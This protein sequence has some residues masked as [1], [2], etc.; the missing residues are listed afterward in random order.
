[1]LAAIYCLNDC[2][3]RGQRGFIGEAPC[4]TA[5]IP[6]PQAANQ[7]RVRYPEELGASA[8]RRVGVAEV[9]LRQSIRRV[10]LEERGERFSVVGGLTEWVIA[11]HEN[12][13]QTSG[14]LSAPRAFG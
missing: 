6:P 2:L 9:E 1:M 4:P 13:R 10:A 14:I 3:R 8:C 5:C 12:P 11:D 7:V